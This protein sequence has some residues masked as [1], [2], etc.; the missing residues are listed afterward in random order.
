MRHNETS[1]QAGIRMFQRWCSD[2]KST[3][4]LEGQTI[5]TGTGC[6]GGGWK[7]PVRMNE[8]KMTLQNVA[9]E[10]GHKNYIRAWRKGVKELERQLEA[11]FDR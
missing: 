4:T 9:F 6:E 5:W 11:Q 2:A 7:L 1:I 8:D 3:R 10:V